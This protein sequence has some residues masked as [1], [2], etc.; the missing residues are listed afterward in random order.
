MT[1]R[2]PSWREAQ[3]ARGDVPRATELFSDQA[4]GY[5]FTE[6]AI[7]TTCPSCEREQSL[8]EAVFD[9]SDEWE[10]KYLCSGC[11]STLLVISTPVPVLW[12]G[13]GY[14]LGDW[15]LRN[16]RDVVVEPTHTGRPIRFGAS[17]HAL[18]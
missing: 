8:D 4:D 13:R 16:P 12:E 5:P 17:P 18:D 1:E 15:Q 6:A 2:F 9:D 7:R 3:K 10:C 14:L 11:L